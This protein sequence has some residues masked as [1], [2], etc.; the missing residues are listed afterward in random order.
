MEELFAPE[1]N[2]I[3][4]Y[5]KISGVYFQVIGITKTL[6]SG[7]MGDR[8]ANT[9]FVPFTTLQATS[10]H[11]GDRVGFFALTAKPG[12]DGPALE[13][14]VREALSKRHHRSTPTDHLAIGSFNMFVMFGKFETVFFCAVGD[15]LDRRRR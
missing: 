2:P 7:Q 9:I 1:V 15:Q 3:G 10:F 4:T 12:T 14:Q 11:M 8:D 13:D 5:I 6:R